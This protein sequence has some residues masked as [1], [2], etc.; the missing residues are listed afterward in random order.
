[1][2]TVVRFLPS[3]VAKEIP[4]QNHQIP[5]K[6]IPFTIDDGMRLKNI[7]VEQ[8]LMD[9]GTKSDNNDGNDG[10]NDSKNSNDADSDDDRYADL[11]GND[12]VN[13]VMDGYD[14]E[15]ELDFL[16]RI[17]GLGNSVAAGPVDNRSNT[18]YMNPKHPNKKIKLSNNIKDNNDGNNSDLDDIMIKKTDEIFVTLGSN[19]DQTSFS[20]EVMIFD[21]DKRHFYIHHDV[22]LPY[23]PLCCKWLNY[24]NNN[25][26]NSNLLAVGGINESIE[27]FDIDVMDALEPVYTLGGRNK[28]KD[29]IKAQKILNKYRMN[30]EFNLHS[31][32]RY[33]VIYILYIHNIIL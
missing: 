26:M 22:I 33:I 13:A 15:D 25:D 21:T 9:D 14:N 31:D 5:L 8:F 17:G 1:M 24:R 6:H 23:F 18:H 10:N 20:L 27:I 28:P 29:P 3:N 32:L 7:D 30:P 16:S 19:E 11:S 2:R 12:F 4:E